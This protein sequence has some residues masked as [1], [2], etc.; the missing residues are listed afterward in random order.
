MMKQRIQVRAHNEAAKT[1]AERI[2]AVLETLKAFEGEKIKLKTGGFSAKFRKAIEALSLTND[3]HLLERFD[4]SYSNTLYFA[5]KVNKPVPGGGGV[6]YEELTAW[7]GDMENGVLTA[8]G[9]PETPRSDY[10]FD[11]ML[12]AQDR[13]DE[14]KQRI[15]MERLTFPPSLRGSRIYR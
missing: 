8:L 15:E 12:A 5:V 7:V 13:I 11:Q 2:P 4:G 1:L 3:H 6:V 14:L 9:N 10:D